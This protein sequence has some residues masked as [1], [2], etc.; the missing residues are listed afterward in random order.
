MRW[1]AAEFQKKAQR[2]ALERIAT[3]ILKAADRP[4]VV[5]SRRSTRRPT[6][7]VKFTLADRIDGH[8]VARLSHLGKTA[9]SK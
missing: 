6:T 9:N 7:P 2:V 4:K 3:R 1:Y 5:K 8:Y